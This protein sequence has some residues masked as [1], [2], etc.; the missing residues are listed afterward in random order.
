MQLE[1][2]H[3]LVP[4]GALGFAAH[5]RTRFGSVLVPWLDFDLSA[6]EQYDEQSVCYHVL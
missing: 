3:R 1:N 6:F 4:E 2:F 5:L